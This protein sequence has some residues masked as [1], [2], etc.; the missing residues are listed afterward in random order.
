MRMDGH[1]KPAPH[2]YIEALFKKLSFPN[3]EAYLKLDRYI[4]TDNDAARLYC[5]IIF[6]NQSPFQNDYNLQYRVFTS[7]GHI[8]PGAAIQVN[9]TQKELAEPGDYSNPEV[10]NTIYYGNW[11]HD[12]FNITL[13][14]TTLHNNGYIIEI[15]LQFGAKHSP[16][17]LCLYT[18]KI[19]ERENTNLQDNIVDM[20]ENRFFNIHESEMTKSDEERL[21]ETL[22]RRIDQ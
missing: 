9:L 5:T 18:I 14:R 19:G 12:S 13:S 8:M 15:R 2:H 20:V 11:L 21:F 3:L 22:G 17:K 6:R 7:H 1:T 4:H 16:M 10:A